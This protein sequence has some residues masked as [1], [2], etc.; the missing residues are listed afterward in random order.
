MLTNKPSCLTESQHQL[1]ESQGWD[2]QEFAQYV[3][4]HPE[5]AFLSQKSCSLIFHVE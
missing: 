1:A 3:I 5:S 4:A 2:A